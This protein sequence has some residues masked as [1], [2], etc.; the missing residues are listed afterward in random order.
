MCGP[1]VGLP[2]N[3]NEKDQKLQKI[4]NGQELSF[5]L[6]TIINFFPPSIKMIFLHTVRY[7][8]KKKVKSI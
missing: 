1:E 6:I 3:H 4:S 8:S 7:I 2:D 5:Q